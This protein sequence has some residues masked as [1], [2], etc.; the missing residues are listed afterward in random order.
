MEATKTVPL[1]S[2]LVA[3]AYLF[4]SKEKKKLSLLASEYRDDL[5]LQTLYAIDKEQ[6]MT[7]VAAEQSTSEVCNQSNLQFNFFFFFF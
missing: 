3:I 2:F 6:T 4:S 7:K 5:T 1:P